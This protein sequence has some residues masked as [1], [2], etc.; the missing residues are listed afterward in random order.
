MTELL[1][2]DALIEQAMKDTG[3]D[4]FDNDTYREGL[5]VFIQSFNGGIEKGWMSE[6]GAGRARNDTLHYLRGRLKVSKY[7]AENPELLDRP[8]EKPVFVMGVPRT[9]TTLMSNLLAASGV[10]VYG[11]DTTGTFKYLPP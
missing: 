11:K 1:V 2:A 4:A 8:V 3:I 9:G 6:G 10:A 5:D 7:L